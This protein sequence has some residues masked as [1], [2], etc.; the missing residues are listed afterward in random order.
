MI[1]KLIAQLVADALRLLPALLRAIRD[2]NPR[3]AAEIARRAALA[4]KARAD[5]RRPQ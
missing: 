1:A 2:G 3:V 4:S 5:I